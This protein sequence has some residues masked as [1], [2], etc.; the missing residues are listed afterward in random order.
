MNMHEDIGKQSNGKT[1]E[2]NSKK[3]VK[4]K[5]TNSSLSRRTRH[6]R[7]QHPFLPPRPQPDNHMLH[8][9]ASRR[10]PAPL[11]RHATDTH[12]RADSRKVRPLGS[13][14]GKKETPLVLAGC[15]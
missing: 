14:A 7:T 5:L 9:H 3:A 1:M 11:K 10:P 15:R 4:T 8:R 6:R 12:A 2:S 13:R